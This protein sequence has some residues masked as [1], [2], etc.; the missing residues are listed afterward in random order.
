[1]DE[2]ELRRYEEQLEIEKQKSMR[3][4]LI[5]KIL[6]KY[7]NLELRDEKRREV[8]REKRR[9]QKERAKKRGSDKKN[10]KKEST[11]NSSSDSSGSGGDESSVDG[12]YLLFFRKKIIFFRGYRI[13]IWFEQKVPKRVEKSD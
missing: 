11:P 9:R 8:R 4:R 10:K 2:E 1:M 7:Y 13:C 3:I 5:N 6:I 12:R